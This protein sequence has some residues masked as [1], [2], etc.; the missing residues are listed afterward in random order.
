MTAVRAVL[1]GVAGALLCAVLQAQRPEIRLGA[2]LATG[3][4]VVTL[5]L[6]GL[7]DGVSLLGALCSQAALEEDYA[8]AMIRATGVAILVEFGAQLCRDAGESALA[9][10]IELAGR[11]TLLGIAAPMLISLTQ[12]L[13][14]MM[15]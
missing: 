11:V 2:A 15:A 5:C 3:L 1:I 12:R 14:G 10:R 4:C 13:G 6:D 7:R 8:Q 9:G